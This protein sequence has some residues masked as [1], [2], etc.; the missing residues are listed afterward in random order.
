MPARRSQVRDGVRDE[1]VCQAVGVTFITG[2]S[3]G[4]G[5][6][7][8]R[9]LA[10]HDA[11]AAVAR[12]KDLL[13][14]LVA[15]IEAV[16][17]RAIARACDVTDREAVQA[18]V[19]RTESTLGPVDRLVANAGGGVAT[20]VEHFDAAEVNDVFALNV[21]GTVHC[22]EAVLPGMLARVA[23]QL[24]AMSS[25]AGYRG[26]P[27]GAAYSGAKAGLTTLME[28]LRVDLRP[29]G[30]DVTVLL[31]GFVQVKSG[32]KK[33]KPF[34]LDL[35]TATARMERSIL[36]RR[37]R[38]AFPLPLVLALSL[39]RSLPA[40]LVDRLLAGRGRPPKAP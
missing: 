33:S 29:R 1:L 30:I 5:R 7:L 9:R 14:T 35:E 13:D 26:L 38:D 16:G 22:I 37:P 25:L 36:A 32:R 8:A 12:R 20:H 23:G 19:A 15:E 34:Q 10:S 28:S 4:I 2:A 39:A 24:V 31:P 27:S 6:S 3:S 17:G 18:A 21:G 11:V 40:S